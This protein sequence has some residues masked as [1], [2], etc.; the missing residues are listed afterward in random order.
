VP[1]LNYP[2]PPPPQGNV[3]IMDS[4]RAA[5]TEESTPQQYVKLAAST[6]AQ[7]I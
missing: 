3:K 7:R 2:E 1:S 4:E 5:F 6:S